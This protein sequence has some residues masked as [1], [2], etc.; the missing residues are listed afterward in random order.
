MM[1]PTTPQKPTSY[2]SFVNYCAAQV[3]RF[4]NVYFLKVTAEA[5]NNWFFNLDFCQKLIYNLFVQF[6]R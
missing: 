1:A 4:F 6:V 3:I 2:S 5:K